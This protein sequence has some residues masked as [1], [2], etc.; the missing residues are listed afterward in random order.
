MPGPGDSVQEAQF[1]PRNVDSPEGDGWIVLLVCRVS[2]MRSDLVV[3]DA[4]QLAAGPVATF[5]IP[6]RVRA[7]FHGMWVP[8]A[9][10]DS[11]LFE[12]RRLDSL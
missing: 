10:L 4:T 9:T 12:A 5:R 8:Q 3:L 11:G 7:T 1:V 6:V 2:R